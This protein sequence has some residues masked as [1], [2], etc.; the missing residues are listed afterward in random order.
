MSAFGLW[1]LIS[2]LWP[3]ISAFNFQLLLCLD[4][5]RWMLDVGCSFSRNPFVEEQLL[6]VETRPQWQLLFFPHGVIS[7]LKSFFVNYR[8][9]SLQ[10][11]LHNLLRSIRIGRF[12]Q[13][14]LGKLARV[15]KIPANWRARSVPLKNKAESW[16]LENWNWTLPSALVISALRVTWEIW[17]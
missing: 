10:S 9:F 4:V 15:R 2:G 14:A 12:N 16:N 6:N 13:L 17:T 8:P 3:L 5:E 1:P 7:A 11:P